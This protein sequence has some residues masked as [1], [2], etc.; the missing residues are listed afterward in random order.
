ML[1]H[2]LVEE[3]LADDDSFDLVGVTE[4]QRWNR[5]QI[6]VVVGYSAFRLVIIIVP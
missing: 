6:K 1:F 5:G 3:D 2:A 4:Q